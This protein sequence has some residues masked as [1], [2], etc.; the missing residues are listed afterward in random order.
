[1]KQAVVFAYDLYAKYYN[2]TWVRP[3]Y[4]AIRQLP[5]IPQEREI[6]DLIAGVNAEIALLL[7]IAKESG[8][9]AGEIY[10]LLWT[11]V[12]FEAHTITLLAEKNS[13]PRCFKTSRKLQNM[14]E[15]YPKS[16]EQIFTQYKDLNNL[17]RTFERQRKR[18]SIKLANPRINKITIHTLRHW[19]GT[20]EYHKT[21]DILHVMQTLGHKNIKNTLLYTQ[22]ISI[23]E[24]NGYIC[25]IAKTPQEAC[26]LIEQS[27]ELHCCYGEH[28]EIKL[29]RKRK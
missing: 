14:L 2:I 29:F 21:K 28:D 1:M 4:K 3:N 22:L 25:K 16:T 8:A 13:N 12:D 15:C 20:T 6:D 7:T 11:D 9:R 23:E 26:E 27:F 10:R 19:K 24:D 17:R 5:F 18:L